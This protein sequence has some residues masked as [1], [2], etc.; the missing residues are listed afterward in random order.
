MSEGLTACLQAR[1]RASH[2]ASTISTARVTSV[3]RSRP[4]RKY[5][6]AH[7]PLSRLMSSRHGL[8]SAAALALLVAG[9]STAQ[10][11]LGSLVSLPH[12]A[13]GLVGSTLGLGGDVPIG[14][15]SP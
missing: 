15:G 9:A 2:P 12:V 6:T 14:I 3:H 11:Q 1:D 5:R 10:A 13:V 7:S 4:W 8:M